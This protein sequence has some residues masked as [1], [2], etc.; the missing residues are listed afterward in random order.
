MTMTTIAATTSSAP[1]A[2]GAA[3]GEVIGA[4]AGAVLLTSA[5]IAIGWAHRTG[6]TD[7]LRRIGDR[8]GELAGGPSWAVL[9]TNI[10]TASLLIAVFGMYWDISLHIGQ[11]RDPGPL[12]NPAHYF[13]LA[14]LFGIFSAGFLAVVL[15]DKRPSRASIRLVGDWYAPL[16]GLVLLACGAF[17]LLGFPLDD[18]WHR[19]FGQDVTLWG[20]TH[21]MLIGGAGLSL[22]G[23]AIL[24]V[25]GGPQTATKDDGGIAGRIMEFIYRTRYAGVCG[26][27]L[28]GLS[29]FQA[30]FD[31]G[32]PQFR[33]LFEPVL[34]AVAA[35]IALVA[36]RT[37]AGRGAALVALAYFL[38][39]RG[40]LTLLVGPVLGEPTPHF[41]LYAAEALI[42]EAVALAIVPRRSP[43]GYG[44]L[45]GLLIGTLGFASEYAWSQVFIPVAWPSELIGEALPFVTLTGVAAGVIGGFVGACLAAPREPGSVRVPRLAVAGVAALAIACVIG[46]GL[47][48]DHVEGVRAQFTLDNA[49]SGA[50]RE[51]DATVRIDP[52]SAATDADWLREIA[53]QGGG[54]VE[55]PLEQTGPGTW[56]TTEPLPVHDDW[57]ALISLQDGASQVGVPIY[58]PED[59]A[60]PADEVPAKRS[61]ERTFVPEHQILQREQKSDVPQALPAI[62]YSIVGIVAIGLIATLGWALARLAGASAPAAGKRAPTRTRSGFAKPAG[63]TA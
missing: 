13:I 30:E 49:S 51:V 33:L 29:T 15:P 47:R 42:V 9:P 38:V 6:R 5:L 50:D 48:T 58:M 8:S 3:I 53:W 16:G 44:A 17:A 62:A 45:C 2:G 36:A 21:L 40:G 22:L 37:Y 12:A 11:G 24:M 14:G 28:V 61:F 31:F 52:A 10:A 20:P 39:V 19:L 54:L 63:G 41:P 59:P 55:A 26:G 34:I 43:V 57:K 27:L 7:L 35:G 32:V 25:E 23:M 18:I 60:I 4:T 56:Q 1:P 46:Y